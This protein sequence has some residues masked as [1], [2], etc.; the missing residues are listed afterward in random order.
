VGVFHF[1]GNKAL[2][3]L[4]HDAMQAPRLWALTYPPPWEWR[5]QHP[6]R[7]APR[8][9]EIAHLLPHLCHGGAGCKLQLKETLLADG[10]L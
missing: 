3:A 8:P 2:I 7:R 1:H 10:Y 9:V 4:Q 5:K 6:I